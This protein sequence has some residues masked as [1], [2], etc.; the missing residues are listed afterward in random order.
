M[1]QYSEKVWE[2]FCSHDYVGE[3]DSSDK[4]VSFGRAGS[5]GSGDV[6]Q[7]YI[8]VDDDKKIVDVKFKAHG[9]CAIIAVAN[10]L[11]NEILHTTL[12]DAKKINWEDVSQDL[13]LPDVRRHSVLLVID[14]I[15]RCCE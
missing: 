4:S 12:S 14:A 10:Y 11:A 2:N 13:S 3:L 15:S 1:I 7:F 8:R 6:V 5:F 9:S